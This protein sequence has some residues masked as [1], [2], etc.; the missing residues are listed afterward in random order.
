MGTYDLFHS[1]E[2]SFPMS[3]IVDQKRKA[4]SLREAVKSNTYEV[5]N[6]DGKMKIKKRKKIV[7][8]KEKKK[9]VSSSD[10]EEDCFVQPKK[11]KR[12]VHKRLILCEDTETSE[13]T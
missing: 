8:T 5:V 6:I 4:E 2:D 10:D 12:R 1:E 13:R 11:K 3:P 7:L 9:N